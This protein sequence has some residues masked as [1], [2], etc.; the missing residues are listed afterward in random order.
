M[1]EAGLGIELGSSSLFSSGL[2]SVGL[3]GSAAAPAA[4]T[5]VAKGNEQPALPIKPRISGASEPE[6]SPQEANAHDMPPL[7]LPPR[8][9][10]PP[11][12]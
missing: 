4:T 10:H 11:L 6:V 2:F 12:Y 9:Q 5:D 3:R 1:D 8:Q 7:E